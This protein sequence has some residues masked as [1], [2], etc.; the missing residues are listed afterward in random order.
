M[1]YRPSARVWAAEAAP[2]AVMTVAVAKTRLRIDAADEDTAVADYVSAATS[3]VEKTTQRLLVART[4]TLRLP[5]FPPAGVA[6]EL[7]GGRVASVTSVTWRDEDGETQTLAP[8]RY[9][10]HGDSP[11]RLMLTDNEG[12]PVTAGQGLPVTVT[13]VAGWPPVG[14]DFGANVPEPLRTAVAILA[15]EMFEQRRESV[16]GATVT[17]AALGAAALIAPWRIRA[18]G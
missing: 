13:Y 3:H 1:M 7:P 8:S 15:G 2:G 12:W 9:E 4:C 5:A 10:V 6:I 17:A 11:A 18:A 14:Q 16:V